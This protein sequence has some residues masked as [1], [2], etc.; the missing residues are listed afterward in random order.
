ARDAVI[1]LRFDAAQFW[2]MFQQVPGFAVAIARGMAFH[3][4]ELSGRVPIPR[5]E[6]KGAPDHG[7]VGLLPL[8][9][10]QR[11]RVLPLESDGNVLTLGFVDDPTSQALEGV[12]QLLPGI[13][14]TP[15]S[16]T[17]RFFDQTLGTLSGAGQW[18]IAEA[19]PPA[20][21]T[22]TPT[23]TVEPSSAPV[24]SA[25]LESWVRR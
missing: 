14:L 16:I 21:S 7:V 2:Q 17:S 11:H 3:L 18:G 8:G 1:A 23:A 20:Y 9:F 12:R 24:R 10:V 4:K 25:D 6:P 15:V 19:A 5:Y 22:A 13:V